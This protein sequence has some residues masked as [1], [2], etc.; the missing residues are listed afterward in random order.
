MPKEFSP[1]EL[2][3]TPREFTPEELGVKPAKKQLSRGFDPLAM[4]M[5]APGSLFKNTI[6]G[7]YEAVTNPIQTA[8]GVLDVAAGGLQNMLPASVRA[9]I[10]RYDP[11]P[12]AAARARA[13]ASAVGQEYAS[14]YGTPS[15]FAQ[16][17]ESDPFRVLGDVSMLAG[18][19]SAAARL[20]RLPQAS[21][22]LART[23]QITNPV[24]ALVGA[25]RLAAP[26]VTQGP[27]AVIGLATG[28]G[29]ETVRTAFRSGQTGNQAFLENMR[30]NVPITDVLD[31]ARA[32][33][34]TI[35]QN[36]Q[37]QY[38]SGMSD[39][40]KDKTVL[41][42]TNI[43]NSIVKAADVGQF[44]GQP[45]N[46]RAADA[47]QEIKAA[48][49]EWKKLDPVEFHTPEGLD[50]LKQKIGS[51]Q[52]AIPFEQRTAQKVAGNIYNSIK[53]EIVKQAPEYSKVMKSYEEASELTKEIERA[54]SLNK[55][56]SADTAIRKLQSL[57]RNNVNT[58]YGQ[59]IQLANELEQ[60]G[61]R[62]IMTALAGQS[63]SS[64]IPRNLAGQ[65][66]GLGTLASS[67]TN[68]ATLAA[69]PFMSPRLMGE[70]AYGLGQ[71]ANAVEQSVPV[72][73]YLTPAMQRL[74]MLRGNIPM[75][76][77]QARMAA[78]IA[79]QAGNSQQQP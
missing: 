57:T 59:R 17:M 45:I 63:M 18:G 71:F 7:L 73:N 2:G 31:D 24:N 41:D 55:R 39:V 25:A 15:G 78:L 8:T 79:A 26:V 19:G 4:V 65:A 38:R 52:E 58:N 77:Q 32:N 62:D 66:A 50:A 64:P 68:P 6:G 43:D 72:Q 34:Q 40:S 16:T 76:P 23:S 27:A 28:A 29:P 49:D 47:L 53:N 9:Y 51:I 30:G 21:Q 20:A 13:A 74:N 35:K 56:A 69:A 75:T 22:A 44:K 48:V 11:N 3:I 61:G 70:T 14:T 33:L 54:L 1:E 60:Q 36:S 67:I 5:N 12:E 42:F 37:A 46:Q 10:D